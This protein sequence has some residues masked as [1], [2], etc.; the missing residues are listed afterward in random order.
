MFCI[1]KRF[2]LILF[3]IFMLVSCSKT[4]TKNVDKVNNEIKNSTSQFFPK[5]RRISCIR[6]TL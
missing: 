4:G 6:K 1:K 3:S 5:Y 2:I